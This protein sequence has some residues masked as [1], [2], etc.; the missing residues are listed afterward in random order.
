MSLTQAA[1][2]LRR[3]L[4][5]MHSV[6]KPL[7]M[8]GFHLLV[9]GLYSAAAAYGPALW[10]LAAARGVDERVLT[11]ALTTL[12]PCVV[13]Y[14]Y[15]ALLYCVDMYGSLAFG[16]ARKVQPS[17]QPSNADYWRCLMVTAR[18]WGI[19]LVLGAV[20]AFVLN[21]LR[22][23]AHGAV[24]PTPGRFVL[25]LIGIVVVEEIMFFYSHRALH[26]PRFY[27]RIHKLHHQFTAPFGIAAV[28]AH[29]VE[30]LLSNVLP[31]A[32]GPI[33]MGSHPVTAAIWT[34]AAIIN[35]MTVRALRR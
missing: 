22:G 2:A 35:T 28:Y 23:G 31:V 8:L 1:A 5:V 14:A 32:A 33:V 24:M 15:G 6:S 30:H 26:Q 18:N 21:P 25:D 11:Y 12:I 7:D 19:S 9:A 16:A 10:K 34:S 20:V 13:F 29:P 3:G 17:F 4:D 27:A